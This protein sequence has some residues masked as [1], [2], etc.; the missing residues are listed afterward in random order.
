M[1]GS[2]Q[3]IHDSELIEGLFDFDAKDVL[4]DLG[5][6]SMSDFRQKL[7]EVESMDLMFTYSIVSA[8]GFAYFL[9]AIDDYARSLASDGDFMFP[10][11]FSHAVENQMRINPEAVFAVK[12]Q[13]L[14][15]CQYLM[16]QLD[17]FNLDDQWKGETSAK[18]VRVL[19]ALG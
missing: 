5:A 6:L 11:P 16:E 9:P 18:L 7:E 8:K 1:E 15:L 17:K 2:E 12:N 4:E 14:L 3:K 13:V 19:K 10:G